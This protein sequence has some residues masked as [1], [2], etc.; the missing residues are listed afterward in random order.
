MGGIVLQAQ[1]LMEL[2]LMFRVPYFGIVSS[3]ITFVNIFGRRT[4]VQ[5]GLPAEPRDLEAD[6]EYWTG[7]FV[8]S[9]WLISARM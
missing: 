5:T 8:L 3:R 2:S 7:F 9:Y 1:I 6:P 4:W